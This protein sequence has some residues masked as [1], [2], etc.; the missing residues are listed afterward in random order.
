M[1]EVKY[2]ICHLTSQDQS[3]KALKPNQLICGQDGNR[4]H[5]SLL[6]KQ[7]R[8]PWYMLAQFVLR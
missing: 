4:T 7:S 3:S 5:H 2:N 1:G 6:A 8:Q